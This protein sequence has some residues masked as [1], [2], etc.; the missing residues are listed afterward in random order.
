MKDTNNEDT[1]EL[2]LP[3]L[4]QERIRS[5]VNE[6]VQNALSETLPTALRQATEKKYLTKRE[7]MDLTGWSARTVEYKKSER[8]IP[9]IRRGRTILF[10]TEEVYAWLEKGRVEAQPGQ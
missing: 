4:W 9:F 8:K 5:L 7:L 6:G 10:P 2:A 3:R 1:G